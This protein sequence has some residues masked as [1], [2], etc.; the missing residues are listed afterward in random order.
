[1]PVAP[2]LYSR[3]V[4]LVYGSFGKYRNHLAVPVVHA[5]Y[6]SIFSRCR[7]MKKLSSSLK[8]FHKV[9]KNAR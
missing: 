2:I 9:V 8:V 5:D 6:F 3:C 4:T 1:M 7:T